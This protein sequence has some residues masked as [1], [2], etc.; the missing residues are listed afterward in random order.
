MI[1]KTLETIYFIESGRKSI[2][3]Y[4]AEINKLWPTP[5]NKKKQT[6]KNRQHLTRNRKKMSIT[7]G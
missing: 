3:S 2:D 1:K 7:F 4:L 6:L 5:K